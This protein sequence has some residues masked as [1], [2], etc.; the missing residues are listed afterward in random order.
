MQASDSGAGLSLVAKEAPVERRITVD[1]LPQRTRR[2]T[3]AAATLSLCSSV[4]SVV[5]KLKTLP[6]LATHCVYRIAHSD[7]N[8][9]RY[10][11]PFATTGDEVMSSPM[12]FTATFSNVLPAFTT[13]I[14]PVRADK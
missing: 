11:V 3:E 4:S 1:F 9:R 5:Q 8:D 12:S 14:F 6:R 7:L 2:N 13:V 10:S